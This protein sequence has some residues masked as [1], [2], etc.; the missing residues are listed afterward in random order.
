MNLFDVLIL[1]G[2][3]AGAAMGLFHGVV[4]QVIGLCI[5][6]LSLV[7]AT[8]YYE[9]AAQWI[10]AVVVV[11]TTAAQSLA[12]SLIL[13]LFVGLLTF[14]TRDYRKARLTRFRMLDQLGGLVLGFAA[15]CVWVSLALAVLHFAV[16]T[17]VSWRQAG[18]PELASFGG[19]SLRLAVYNG[20]R[21]SPL[22]NVFGRLLPFIAMSVKPWTP[23]DILRILSWL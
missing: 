7:L 13:A 12:F 22:A 19:E 21:S 14:V 4:R 20:L 1:G 15:A 9:T 3:L 10:R 6:Y 16:Q 8:A 23:S 17:P 2:V 5:L 18:K 11:N